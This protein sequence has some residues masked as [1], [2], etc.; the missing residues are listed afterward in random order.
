MEIVIVG[1]LILLN[2][3]L[4]MSEFAIVSARGARLRHRATRGNAGARV[5]LKLSRRPDRFLS[6]V[7]VGITLVGI[8]AGAFGGAAIAED[9]SVHL[10]RVPAIAP[11]APTVALVIVVGL[12]TYLTLVIGEL[13]P[14][15]IAI[16]NP[17]GV[18]SRVAPLMHAL[19]IVTYP[20]VWLLSVSTRIV[21]KLLRQGG[22]SVSEVTE[23]EVRAMVRQGAEVGVFARSEARM[24]SGV[25]L[26]DDL[27]A[28]A[29]MTPR[30]DV[31][32]I[33]VNAD[34]EQIRRTL[35]TH[36]HSHFPVCDGQ[37]DLVLGIISARTLAAA[38]L[39]DQQPTLAL[40]VSK[41]HFVPES[42]SAADLLRHI[43][44]TDIGFLVVMGE[45]GGVD[46]IVTTYD[47]AE[48]VFG[49]LGT[50]DARKVSDTAWLVDGTMPLEELETMVAQERRTLAGGR[51]YA[52][53]AGLVLDA[54]GHIPAEEEQVRIGDYLFT[55]MKTHRHRIQELKIELSD[56]HPGSFT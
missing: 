5:A 6:T 39:E 3:L 18:A 52:T 43:R 36:T 41:P 45:H 22:D 56:Q 8:L 33:D 20:V 30:P 34:R 53:V 2:G 16:K 35:N 23:D 1:A 50:P 32:W 19:S 7:Q 9:L 10:R 51:R 29:I 24:I 37:P 48:A 14:K 21:L 12:T 15:R 46:G 26:L 54:L 31:V 27:R 13:V 44:S 11:Y 17:E 49:D 28:D 55:V 40:L 4:S 47:L 38:L 25:F 42:S